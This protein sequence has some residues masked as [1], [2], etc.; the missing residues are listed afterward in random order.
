MSS[1]ICPFCF[2]V[3]DF[4]SQLK[5]PETSYEVPE[6][7]VSSFESTPPLWLMTVGFRQHGKTC[8]IAAL[9]QVLEAMQVWSSGFFV[10]L[11][12][13]TF[14]RVREI[15]EKVVV[16]GDLPKSTPPGRPRPLLF[17]SKD[18]PG[19]DSR[20][21]VVYDVPG[22][23]F[24]DFDRVANYAPA[25][26]A[27]QTVWFFVCLRDLEE[28]HRGRTLQELFAVYRAGMR[29]LRIEMKGRTLIVVFTKFDQEE[30]PKRV[31]DY[32]I[33]DPLNRLPAL[34]WESE[35]YIPDAN[36]V[37]NIAEYR[38]EMKEISDV[39]ERFTRAEVRGGAGFL[40]MARSEE[41][42]V[43]FTATSALGQDPG[44]DGKTLDEIAQPFRVLDPFLWAA[45]LKAPVMVRRFHLVLDGAL[46]NNPSGVFAK[47]TE[48]WRR[49][50]SFA[51]VNTYFLGR[52]SRAAVTGQPPPSQPP[53]I[54]RPRLIG[55]LL[56]AL[57][58]RDQVLILTDGPVADLSD[59]SPTHWPR[60]SLLVFRKD[61][62]QVDG[63]WQV[64]SVTDSVDQLDEIVERFM[65]LQ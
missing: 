31:A 33:D 44:H 55:P 17:Q 21:L 13:F 47:I 20:C 34:N 24:D 58:P 4:R 14:E 26:K 27:V 51:E 53:E 63:D 7:Y 37:L 64:V 23:S 22:E 62:C 48:L 5:C 40:A 30:H 2:H 38:R 61:A 36:A 18:L 15:R 16:V 65:R 32:L 1:V 25:M 35:G 43:V 39:L 29:R 59:F 45:E 56:E 42:R 52:S 60:R 6:A 3:H 46:R 41:M 49:L 12:A 50:A 54:S 28:V 10:A 11:D 8:F 9:T 19:I 57:E